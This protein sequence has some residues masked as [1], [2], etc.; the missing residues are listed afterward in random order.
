M[1]ARF[2]GGLADWILADADTVKM[3]NVF[4]QDFATI[5]ND[6]PYRTLRQQI[7][8]HQLPEFCKNCYSDAGERPVAVAPGYQPIKIYRNPPMGG[9]AGQGGQVIEG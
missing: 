4:E 8:D 9:T 7:R 6:A 1:Q 2:S 5:W 3:G